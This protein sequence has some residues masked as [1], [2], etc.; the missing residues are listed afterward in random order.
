MA[1]E[2]AKMIPQIVSE[3]HA[4]SSTSS[5]DSKNDSP[6]A[7]F[8]F[9]QFKACGLMNFTGEDGPSMMFQWFDS[10]EVTFP[11]SGCP[12]NLRTV[13]A[14]GVFQSR[15]LDWW[16]AERNR[17]GNDATYDLAW[18]ELREPMIN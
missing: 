6:K 16:T 1:K 7:P 5:V 13:K 15:A 4:V 18:E 14:I 3:I 17:R 10:M 12:K 8:S 2:M 9:K 11:Q